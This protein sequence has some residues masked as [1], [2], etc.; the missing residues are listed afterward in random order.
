M[1][2]RRRSPKPKKVE[3]SVVV[4]LSMSMT[5]QTSS[6]AIDYSLNALGTSLAFILALTLHTHS[7]SARWLGARRVFILK[8]KICIAQKVESNH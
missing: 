8:Q 2:A 7:K 6:C 5:R 4:E 1:R 3:F